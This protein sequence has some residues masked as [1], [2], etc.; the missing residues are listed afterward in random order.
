MKGFIWMYCLKE[1]FSFI[2]YFFERIICLYFTI[3]KRN[4]R[5]MEKWLF[6]NCNYVPVCFSFINTLKFKNCFHSKLS[7]LY[8]IFR[9]FDTSFVDTSLFSYIFDEINKIK[10]FNAYIFSRVQFVCIY[11]FFTFWK[12]SLTLELI[13]MV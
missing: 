12:S 11:I 9:D 1:A 6:G 4:S 5:K 10:I 2:L 8:K 3:E 7:I 13:S